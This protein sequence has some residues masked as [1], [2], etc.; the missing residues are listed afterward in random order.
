MRE[1]VTIQAGS[2]LP[3]LLPRIPAKSTSPFVTGQAGNQVATAFWE[4]ILQEHGLSD[5][6]MIKDD[7]TREQT[8]RLNV[9]FSEACKLPN[10]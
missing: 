8:E 4:T 3:L 9:F 2:S 6:G 1:L 5:E 7:A 10:A